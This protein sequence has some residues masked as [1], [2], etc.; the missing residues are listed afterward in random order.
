MFEKLKQR[1]KEGRGYLRVD[2][3]KCA[4]CGIC[5]KKCPSKAI[6]VIAS[7]KEWR[8]DDEKCIRCGHCTRRCPNRALTIVKEMRD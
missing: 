7:T 5:R 4:C 6:T 2:T 3:G 8:V 1:T